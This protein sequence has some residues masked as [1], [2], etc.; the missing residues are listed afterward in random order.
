MQ[1]EVLRFETSVRPIQKRVL[2]DVIIPLSK[3]IKLKNGE[4]TDSVLLKKGDNIVLCTSVVN[5]SK[6]IWGLDAHVFRPER[7]LDLKN[8]TDPS[9][10]SIIE[11]RTKGFPMFSN[12]LTFMG[13]AR[14]CI[15]T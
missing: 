2:E 3:P 9:R 5:K 12:I 8:G 6:D 1:R 15:G 11:E 14:G 13:G 7:W 4:I 10:K